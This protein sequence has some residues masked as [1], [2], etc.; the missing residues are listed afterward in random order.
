MPPTSCGRLAAPG[1]DRGHRGGSTSA[2]SSWPW[3]QPD[4]SPQREARASAPRRSIANTSTLER[5]V[6]RAWAPSRDIICQTRTPAA[7]RA[8]RS[9]C[10]RGAVGSPRETW[11]SRSNLE[12][13]YE[14]R[15]LPTPQISA[16]SLWLRL[17]GSAICNPDSHT[18]SYAGMRWSVPELATNLGP[19][20][21]E[22]EFRSGR[23]PEKSGGQ[24][25]D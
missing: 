6:P 22:G 24:G 4:L 19:N 14:G 7:L 3:A 11:R 2:S 15:S 12:L 23:V 5:R 18:R 21:A 17:A 9:Q 16:S 8:S 25:R 10:H 13:R 1:R 20:S